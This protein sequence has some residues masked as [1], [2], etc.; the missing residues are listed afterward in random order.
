MLLT[1]NNAV[2]VYHDHWVSS[3]IC[4]SLHETHHQPQPIENQV[5]VRILPRLCQGQLHTTNRYISHARSPATG[6]PHIEPEFGLKLPRHI[7]QDLSTLSSLQLVLPG[8]QPMIGEAIRT[9]LFLCVCMRF[10]VPRLQFLSCPNSTR[11]WLWRLTCL[12][13]RS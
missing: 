5:Y 2:S 9:L 12:P 6:L 3:T 10:P 4:Q 11:C 13:A 8:F 7:H 1:L